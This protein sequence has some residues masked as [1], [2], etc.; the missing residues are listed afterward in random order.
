MY[1]KENLKVDFIVTF[2]SLL[3]K[4]GMQTEKSVTRNPDNLIINT[5]HSFFSAFS[6]HRKSEEFKIHENFKLYR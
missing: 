5:K 3:L 4:T 6:H 2:Q 1:I